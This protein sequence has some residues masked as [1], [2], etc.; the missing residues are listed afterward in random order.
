MFHKKVDLY[1]KTEN[2]Y[3]FTE[4]KKEY[5]IKLE[6]LDRVYSE[7][8][9]FNG[10]FIRLYICDLKNNE[11]EFEEESDEIFYSTTECFIKSRFCQYKRKFIGEYYFYD[12]L[13]Y[14]FEKEL[15]KDN[16]KTLKHLLKIMPETIEELKQQYKKSYKRYLEKYYRKEDYLLKLNEIYKQCIEDYEDKIN[17]E[18]EDERIKHKIDFLYYC[19]KYLGRNNRFQLVVSKQNSKFVLKIAKILM[20]TTGIKIRYE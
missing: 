12:E 6:V 9:D 19:E 1:M 10:I 20:K 14:E 7:Y 13:P 2:N 18:T 4:N 3:T 11:L 15:L 8:P 5:K 17:D 16:F